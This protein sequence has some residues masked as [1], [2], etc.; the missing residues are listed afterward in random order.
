MRRMPSRASSFW[1]DKSMKHEVILALGT[2]VGEACMKQAKQLLLEEMEDICFTSTL[3]TEAIGIVSPSFLNC[4]A[5]GITD[6]DKE[7]L[8]KSLKKMERLC[9]DTRKKRR[10][11]VITMD[12]DL[13]RFDDEMLHKSD[14]NRDYIK[15]LLTEWNET[16]LH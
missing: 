14:W 1:K 7:T 3:Q 6:K 9:G 11:N 15:E 2:N 5:K 12:I 13:L 8:K 4:L 16:I 10:E